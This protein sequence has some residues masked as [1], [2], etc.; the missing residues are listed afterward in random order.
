MVFIGI[1]AVCLVVGVGLFALSKS[2]VG[3]T[4]V[5]LVAW[6]IIPEETFN[7][8]YRNSSL[9]KNKT[10]TVSYVKKDPTTFDEDF[11]NALADGKGPDIVLLRNDSVYKNRN[12]L[13]TIPY[14]S[15]TERVFKDNFIEEGEIY[16]SPSGVVALP[17]MV[18]PLVMYWNRDMFSNNLIV[19]PPKYWDE[20]YA[21][22]DKITKKDSNANITQSAVALGG[23]NNITNA[24]EIL[25]TLLL[26][27]GTPII[28]RSGSGN[29]SSVLNSQFS[30]AVAP[31][32][33]AVNFYTQFS[34]P[35]AASYTW[36][37][38]LPSSLNMFLSGKL[39]TY[40]GFASEI[41]SIQQKNSNLNFDVT[42]VPQVRNST[43]KN[44]FAQ[45]YALAVVKQSRQVAPAFAAI[46]S[47]TESTAIASLEK[48][49]NLPPVRRDLLALAPSDDFKIVFYN[50]ALYAHSWIDPDAAASA[51]TFRDM[52]ENITSGRA[53]QSEALGRA[54]DELNLQ[55]R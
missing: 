14:K 45:M 48:V 18:D 34:N 4:T 24:K 19:S 46:A 31:S 2:G 33:S 49:T 26:Q 37:R 9:S 55:L 53:R 23:W 52:I 51:N 16:L 21:L 3:K 41:S 12:R 28:S 25:V 47:L 11:I 6:G 1:F 22:I 13:F 27:A 5:K 42:Y 35:T 20:M 50:S 54:N 36:N 43:K 29:V 15:Y 44:V 40:V 8:A 7:L 39:A 38:S 10:I 17:F 32:Q 30:Y